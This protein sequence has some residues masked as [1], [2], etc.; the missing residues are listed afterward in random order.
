[1]KTVRIA[2]VDSG[3]APNHPHVGEIA[4]GVFF[5]N[6]HPADDWTDRIGHG[7]AVAGAIREKAPDAALYAVRVFEHRLATNIVNLAAALEWCVEQRV[8]IVNL[9]LGTANPAHRD[10][11]QP[12]L[13]RCRERGI[14]VVSAAGMLPGSLPGA[15]A[16]ATDPEC[17][18]DTWRMR[19]GILTASPYPRDIPGVPREYNLQGASFAV[20]NFT[21]LLAARLSRD[22]SPGADIAPA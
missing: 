13:D 7:T 20:A 8:D 19:D 22:R 11:F 17:P 10:L 5:Q 4:G 1:M 9:S 21:G 6:G 16:I 12:L 14:S 3:I 15:L 2:V 18:R